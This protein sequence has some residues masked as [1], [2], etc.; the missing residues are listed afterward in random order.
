M[1]LNFI[2]KTNNFH[3]LLLF[4]YYFIINLFKN[5]NFLQKCGKLL[6]YIYFRIVIFMYF[7]FNKVY[8][9]VIFVYLIIQY[10]LIY[11]VFTYNILYYNLFITENLLLFN[12]ILLEN[13]SI[14]ENINFDINNNHDLNKDFN[15]LYFDNN[16]SLIPDNNNGNDNNMNNMNNMNNRNNFDDM[17]TNE[18]FNKS[19]N[20]KDQ[21]SD[22]DTITLFNRVIHLKKTNPLIL[23]MIKKHISDND[24]N[25]LQEESFSFVKNNTINDN[26]NNLLPANSK[27]FLDNSNLYSDN[28]K[29]KNSF[30]EV[31]NPLFED[32]SSKD[33]LKMPCRI[34][35]PYVHMPIINKTGTMLSLPFYN[36]TPTALERLSYELNGTLP[37]DYLSV[38]TNSL[39]NTI[40]QDGLD[41]IKL[42]NTSHY[43]SLSLQTENLSDLSDLSDL[44]VSQNAVAS[45]SKIEESSFIQGS[46]DISS[47]LLSDPLNYL[48]DE[49]FLSHIL[50]I[51]DPNRM[52]IQP[53]IG[54]FD[55]YG[56]L[57][58]PMEVLDNYQVPEYMLLNYNC[59][60]QYDS[61]LHPVLFKGML[62]EAWKNRYFD[63]IIEFYLEDHN[64]YK[65]YY[66]KD[67][68]DVIIEY[69]RDKII[70]PKTPTINTLSTFD[71]TL[72]TFDKGKG[73]AF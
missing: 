6:F 39:K 52:D 15:I 24:N 37:D 35:G 46:S 53:F 60:E 40:K 42:E 48:P 65:T 38:S 51:E 34:I 64:M 73:K 67:N 25:I 63:T 69:L 4:E 36:G 57:H 5:K 50:T 59:Y 44:S 49:L 56:N 70:Y 66:T 72:S 62:E 9:K 1:N 32:N 28:S 26:N 61:D 2:T 20:N 10:L 22:I 30:M 55:V 27:L 23:D 43:N 33:E 58:L 16:K 12:N 41:L 3:K 29:V 45:S 47:N 17:N 21:E 13:Y 19:K 7:S 68:L 54:G 31:V 18:I 8:S 71:N 11:L 14:F